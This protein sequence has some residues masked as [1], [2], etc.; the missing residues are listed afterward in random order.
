MR[1]AVVDQ[2]NLEVINV[3]MWE[4]HTMEWPQHWLVIPSEI[5][6]IGDSYNPESKTFHH[7]IRIQPDIE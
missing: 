6:Q 4:G 5:A 2:R 7:V 1:H 3:I